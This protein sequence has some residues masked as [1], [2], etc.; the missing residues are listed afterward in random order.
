MK[1]T[2]QNVFTLIPALVLASTG[3]FST[4]ALAH[5]SAPTTVRLEV[6]HGEASALWMGSTK[7]DYGSGKTNLDTLRLS[8]SLALSEK[9]HIDFGLTYANFA[10]KGGMVM[11]KA[12]G[13]ANAGLAEVGGHYY[14]TVLNTNGFG[15]DLGAGVRA[16]GNNDG[17]ADFLSLND[18]FTKFDYI[19][20]FSWSN[21]F[22]GVSLG[23]RY[24]DRNHKN[25]GNQMLND[26]TLSFR[27][28]ESLQLAATYGFF[29]TDSG[30]DVGMGIPFNIVK[31]DYDFMGLSI[32]YSLAKVM[33]N[34]MSVDLRYLSKMN[35]R[36]T[37]NTQTFTLGM[38]ASY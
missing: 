5:D 1:M 9:S 14:Y 23:N 16:P 35:G 22:M 2:N 21:A 15:I 26:L 34:D 7:T 20:N 8:S 13:A 6:G 10:A 11:G 33:P 24:T 27:A 32:G 4:P 30:P 31:E 29:R 38:E 18:G 12:D 37:D 25:V 19:A 3:I 17:G 36:N 28:T